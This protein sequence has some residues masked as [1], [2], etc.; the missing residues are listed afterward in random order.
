VERLE[1]LVLETL[2]HSHLVPDRSNIADHDHYHWAV[3]GLDHDAP[4]RRLTLDLLDLL[5]SPHSR[6]GVCAD[7]K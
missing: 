7:N 1:P 4:R 5:S 2:A 3:S 6:V